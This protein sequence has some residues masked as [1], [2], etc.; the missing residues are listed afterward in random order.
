MTQALSGRILL[1]EDQTARYY[2]IPGGEIVSTIKDLKEKGLNLISIF[3]VEEFEGETGCSLLYVLENPGSEKMLILVSHGNGMA[4][5]SV[6]GIFPVASL[7]E[8]EIADGFGIVFTGA[9]DTRRLFLHEAYPAGFHPLKKEVQNKP[10]TTVGENKPGDPYQFKTIEGSSVFQVPVGPVHAGIIEPGHFRFSVIGETIVNLEIRL[11]YL[12]R[13]LEKCAEGKTPEQTVR[14]AESISGD[15]SAV[16]ACGLCMAIEQICGV[17]IPPRAEY[18]RGVLLELERACSLLSDLAGMVTDI[19]HPVS[20]SRFTVLREH[21]QREADQICGSRFLKGAICPG[22]VSDQI[23]KESLDHLF[24]NAGE[25]ERELDEIA[26]WVLSIPSVIDRFATTGVVQPEL[27]RSLALSGPVAR[28]SGS[29]ADTRINHPYGVYRERIPGQVCEQG[30]DV[31]ARF[32]LKHQEIRASLRLIQE[33]IVFLPEG[34]AKI[35]VQVHDGFALSMAESPRGMVLHWVYIRNGFIDR[36]KV[37]TASFCNWYAIEH[38][39]IGNIVADFPVINKSL[40]L[41]YAGTDL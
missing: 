11:G 34:P 15:E 35:P 36:Y 2:R 9:F 18:I 7:F 8:R 39:V 3:G 4:R 12:H 23:S 25:I 32:T 19:A 16:N 6:S 29:F 17:T 5:C 40:N 27:I 31:L 37:R 20:A 22:G 1:K 10:P 38:A 33:L 28:A 26:G 30:G 41:S 13:G 21:I 24:K 14:I